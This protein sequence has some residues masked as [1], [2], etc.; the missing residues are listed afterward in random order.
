MTNVGDALGIFAVS[1]R[2]E[3][4]RRVDTCSNAKIAPLRS[5]KSVCQA[6]MRL[7]LLEERLKSKL[8]LLVLTS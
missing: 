1:A 6:I 8:D 5:V 4:K 3:V 2:R 7:T